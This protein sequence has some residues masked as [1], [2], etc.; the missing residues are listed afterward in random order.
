MREFFGIFRCCVNFTNCLTKD[1]RPVIEKFW[2]YDRFS[3]L[4]I[5]RLVKKTIMTLVAS[6]IVKRQFTKEPFIDSKTPTHNNISNGSK[7]LF[8]EKKGDSQ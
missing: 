7:K 5:E 1:G 4:K 3:V 8:Y 6:S 2:D